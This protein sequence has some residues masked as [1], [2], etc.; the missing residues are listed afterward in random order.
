MCF[1]VVKKLFLVVVLAAVNV[2]SFAY[3]DR[4][5]VHGHPNAYHHYNDKEFYIEGGT[6]YWHG[7]HYYPHRMRYYRPMR[8]E[9]IRPCHGCLPIRRCFHDW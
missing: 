1:Q 4:G 7:H 2:S 6:H 3:W 8:C 9:I 5:Y